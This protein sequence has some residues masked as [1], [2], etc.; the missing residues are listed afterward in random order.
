MRFM[1]IR[2]AD[3]DTEAGKMPSNDLLEAMAK[4]N[5]ELIKAGL[6]LDGMGLHPSSAGAKIQF[7]NGKPIIT[8]GPFAETRELI[9]GFTLIQTKSKEEALEWVK[10][11]PAE[12]ADGR[13]NLELRRVFEMEDFAPG[14]G[15]EHHEQNAALLAASSLRLN[16][17]LNFN[18]N[19]REAFEYYEKVLGGKIEVLQTFGESPMCDQVPPEMRDMVVHVHLNMGNAVLMGSDAPPN[20]FQ[21]NQGISNSLNVPSPEEAERI[22]NAL[23][24]KGTVVMPLA[25]TFWARKFGALQDQFGIH[26][27]I[28]CT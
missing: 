22:F 3:A 7:Q 1:I 18:G 27:M 28:N 21:P 2:K 8:D 6:M 10:R 12:D 23:A 5:E 14:D 15:I 11:W 24:D 4:Y 20:R 17:Y 26:W 19:C 9:A 13:A 25:E 16:P